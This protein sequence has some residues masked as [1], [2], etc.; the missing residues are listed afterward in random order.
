MVICFSA[1]ISWISKFHPPTLNCCFS[2]AGIQGWVYIGGCIM[3][4][5]R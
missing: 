2:L 3:L 4:Q 1:A 5:Q